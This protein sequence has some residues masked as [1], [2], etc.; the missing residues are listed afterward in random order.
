MLFVN[1]EWAVPE[2]ATVISREYPSET[3]TELGPDREY[4]FA[5][6]V[7]YDWEQDK[8]FRVHSNTA[9]Y[10]EVG[11]YVRAR[12]VQVHQKVN[13]V[14]IAGYGTLDNHYVPENEEP[15]I[16]DDASRQQI[17]VFGKNIQVFGVTMI[18]TYPECS[19]FG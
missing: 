15:G 12:I 14:V 10:F 4:V 8:V 7:N 9:V 19:F 18:N 2:G 1:P 3:L 11:A 5:A 17:V 16:G 13:N 6:G